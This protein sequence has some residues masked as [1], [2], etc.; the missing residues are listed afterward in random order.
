VNSGAIFVVDNGLAR[1]ASGPIYQLKKWQELYAADDPVDT[2]GGW[3][4][5]NI[6]RLIN[7][8]SNLNTKQE[9]YFNVERYRLSE[10]PNRNM[11]NGVFVFT[12]Y[13][14]S[15]NLYLAGLR[16]DGTAVIKRKLNGIYQTLATVPFANSSLY[17]SKI[18]P[19]LLPTGKWI[20]MAL[21]SKNNSDGTV[22]IKFTVDLNDGKGWRVMLETTD[23]PAAIS[24]GTTL[25]KPGRG[26]IRTD[27]LDINFKHYKLQAL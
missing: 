11:T 2:D 23:N 12:R 25:L 20:G 10:S 21:E 15:Q 8:S 14:D 24:H 4:P 6:F 1:T 27:F 19:N 13:I 7:S 9:V 26:G 5:Q 18:N 22:G 17:D 3:Y 16:V